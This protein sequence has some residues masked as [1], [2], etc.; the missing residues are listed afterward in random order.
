[1]AKFAWSIPKK[2]LDNQKKYFLLF[3]SELHTCCQKVQKKEYK[4]YLTSASNFLWYFCLFFN[5][6]WFFSREFSIFVWNHTLNLNY[7]RVFSYSSNL[8]KNYWSIS[9]NIQHKLQYIIKNIFSVNSKGIFRYK[10][11]RVVNIHFTYLYIH[12]YIYEL[13]FNICI[14]IY[15]HIV[16]ILLC[17][18]LQTCYKYMPR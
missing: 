14:F 4:A 9:K 5:S 17:N 1:M 15:T 16:E 11:R 12:T 8:H 18:C 13:P 2:N 7:L 3:S 6:S 10:C